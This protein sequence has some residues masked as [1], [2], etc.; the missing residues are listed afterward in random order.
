[1]HLS[2]HSGVHGKQLL[3]TNFSTMALCIDATTF[4]CVML[5]YKDSFFVY[6]ALSAEDV[7]HIQPVS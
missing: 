7:R 3:Y 4:F 6:P 2:N 1:M 5:L